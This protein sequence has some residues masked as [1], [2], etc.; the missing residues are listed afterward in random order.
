M[1][2]YPENTLKSVLSKL[3]IMKMLELINYRTD[4]LQDSEGAIKCFC[5]IHKEVVFR[6]LVITKGDKRFR[7]SYSLC[8]G[9]KGG[10]LILLYALATDRDYD[11]CV[12]F[13]VEHFG[14]DVDL[15]TSKEFVEKTVEIAENY[16]ELGALDEAEHGFK[17]VIS[18]DP[19]DLAAHKGLL[20]VYTLLNDEPKRLK[21]LQDMIRLYAERK[22]YKEVVECAKKVLEKAPEDIEVRELLVD[23]YLGLGDHA[24]AVSE[25]MMLADTYESAGKF[26]EALSLY[27]KIDESGLDVVDVYP[28]IIQVLV[29]A[30]KT[31]E[32]IKETLRRAERLAS[33]GS[34]E[35]ALEYYKYVL[36]MD[37]S[38]NDVRRQYV[39][40]SLALGMNEKRIVTCLAMIDEMLRQ[41]TFSDAVPTLNDM[42]TE[43]PNS[44]S[45]LNKLSEVYERQGK[46]EERRQVQLKMADICQ[47]QGRTREAMELLEQLLN[48]N[49]EDTDALERI[50]AIQKA[51]GEK[52]SSIETYRKIAEI[53][54]AQERYEDAVKIYQSLVEIEPTD[55]TSRREQ[56]QLYLAAGST[57][58]A[59]AKALELIDYLRSKKQY[60]AAIEESAQLIEALPDVGELRV[61][62]AE[63]LEKLRRTDEA[64]EAYF[65]AHE[66][67]KRQGQ[68]EKAAIQ[69][70]RILAS[71]GTNI[72]ALRTQAE[73]QAEMGDSV[74]ALG[75]L[76]NLATSLIEQGD[77]EEARAVLKRILEIKPDDLASLERLVKVNQDLKDDEEL[78]PAYMQQI[79]IFLQREAFNK[80]IEICEAIL[81]I[82]PSDTIVREKLIQV[83]ERTNRAEKALEQYLQ[84]A[85]L[86]QQR[87]EHEKEREVYEKLVAL[88]SEDTEVRRRYCELL[89]ESGQM[90]DASAQLELIV[91]KYCAEA[92]FQQ[93]IDLLKEYIERHP[94]WS[95][96]LLKLSEVYRRAGKS[97]EQLDATM[98]LIKVHEERGE[99]DTVA[100]L[101]RELLVLEPQN[102]TLRNNLIH[103]LLEARKPDEAKKEYAILATLYCDAGRYDD[104]ETIYREML[105]QDPDNEAVHRGLVEVYRK[106][107]SLQQATEQIYRLSNVHQE[108]G[109]IDRAISVLREVVDFDPQNVD[110][111]RKIIELDKEAKRIDDALK[112]F[113]AIYDMHVKSNELDAAV[114][115][116]KEA[117]GLKPEEPGLRRALVDTYVK[118]GNVEEAV[119]ELFALADL[120]ADKEDHEEALKV[121]GEILEHD[122]QNLRAKRK[123]AEAFARLGKEKKA[124]EEFLRLAIVFDNMP[125]G[126]GRQRGKVAEEI[127]KFRELPIVSEYS[128]EQFV[129]GDRNNFAFATALAVAKS[130][131]QS[132]NPLFFYSDVG[133]GKTHLLHAIANY[134]MTHSPNL[135]VL[136][137]NSEEFTSELIDAIQNNTVIAFRSRYKNT[138]VLLLD[139]VQFLAGKERAQ[140]EFFHIFNTLFQ[141]KKQIVL[142][143]D[144]PPKDIA[145]LEKRLRSRFGGGVIV[146]IQPPDF[147]TRIAILHKEAEAYPGIDI[148]DDVFNVIAER[149][150]SNVRDLKAA[151]NQ[152]IAIHQV[153]QERI[154]LAMAQRVMENLTGKG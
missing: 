99:L 12:D 72:K 70:E 47:D 13:L 132:Y 92:N 21:V 35:Q 41:E 82:N 6:T 65:K 124:L 24:T 37:D 89:L 64:H 144:R 106:Q 60:E 107:G 123:R 139:D 19:N 151:L 140:E 76:H 129:V 15:P 88:R 80:A 108:Q 43:A 46:D 135:K 121:V 86:Y 25:C 54:K 109:A 90:S 111:R 22:E 103:T 57:E 119:E 23:G 40:V 36:E 104:A 20:E 62:Q 115:V 4:T 16:L 118:Q 133:L 9:H 39:K 148:G 112:E 71:E 102:F 136:Y 79:E 29:A 68:Q 137:T 48:R 94:D 154:A 51:Q 147:E 26:S 56:I 75:T 146:D 100:S 30:N 97:A 49:A 138:D 5:P 126:E 17:K 11:E 134:V 122:P 127:E 3:D 42:I 59:V 2:V 95:P 53:L 96:A 31:D 32:A 77:L 66:L 45:I 98:R 87:Q 125:V 73:L 81:A 33:D 74:K 110:V 38:R 93:A 149:I 141:G 8:K 101:Y 18:I 34:Y 63:L 7:C 145:H 130:P 153:T 44:L 114:A 52:H 69:L 116:Q 91:E 58:R 50:A 143:S 128:F 14:L 152:L 113:A 105:E 150:Q 117:V 67:F 83:Y 142:T 10:D 28:H 27:R 78:I 84:L 61:N 55:C 85:A 131:A 1:S 120:Y